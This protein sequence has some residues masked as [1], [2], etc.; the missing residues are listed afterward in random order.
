MRFTNESVAYLI[1]QNSPSV[2]IHI[3]HKRMQKM[4]LHLCGKAEF[5]SA[6]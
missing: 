1:P 2:T 5:I 4:F 6:K 3:Y